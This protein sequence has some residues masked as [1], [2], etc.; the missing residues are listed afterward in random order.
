[1]GF[2]RRSETL[3]GMNHMHPHRVRADFQDLGD[4]SFSQATG[5]I[6]QALEFAFRKFGMKEL[7][8]TLVFH[9][10]NSLVR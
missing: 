8:V 7:M 10:M 2:V 3:L 5:G 6:V 1:M 4:L 9:L